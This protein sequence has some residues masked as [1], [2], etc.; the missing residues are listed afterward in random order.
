MWL[1]TTAVERPPRIMCFA[2]EQFRPHRI[3]RLRHPAAADLAE[4]GGC[5]NSV[6]TIASRPV[7]SRPAGSHLMI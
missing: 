3:S 1:Q 7:P 2:L 5:P 4:N 6:P